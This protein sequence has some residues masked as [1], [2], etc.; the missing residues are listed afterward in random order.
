[1]G[2]PI[3]PPAEGGSIDGMYRHAT[4]AAWLGLAVNLGLAVVKL[5]AGIVGDSI[6]MI[7]D[8]VNSTGDVLTSGVILY[9]LRVAQGPA[10]DEHSYGHSRAEVVAALSV[11]ILI[12]VSALGVGLEA[13]GNLWTAHN[14]PP[15]YVLW[16]A[17]ANVVIKESIYRY[18]R[19]VARQT[20]SQ[21]IA[22]GAWD[23]RSD[24]MCS[25]AVLVGLAVVRYGGEAYAWA[26]EVAAT[27]VVGFILVASIKLYRESASLLMDERCDPAIAAGIQR[28]A[29]Q[30]PGVRAVEQIR[31]RRS[32]LEVFVDIHIEVGGSLTVDQGHRI[33]HDVQRRI[34]AEIAPVTQVLV[35][36]EPVACERCDAIGGNSGP[37]A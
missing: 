3:L 25:A 23:H 15:V 30:T 27:V 11:A 29:E 33:G 14:V 8:A 17:A 1:M 12:A 2:G 18:K 28:I 26:D 24:A 9:A 7:A 19:R 31:S 21:A 10:D 4:R 34:L 13:V 22:T 6:A 20:G 35:H 37:T 16:I 5:I 32:G 36:V